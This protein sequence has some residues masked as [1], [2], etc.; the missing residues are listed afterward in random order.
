MS[1]LLPQVFIASILITALA[2]MGRSAIDTNARLYT[3]QVLQA[4]TALEAARESLVIESV[5]P[6]SPAED[7]SITLR[8]DGKR[9]IANWSSIDLIAVYTTATGQV[10]EHLSHTDGAVTPGTWAPLPTDVYQPGILNLDETLN[11]RAYLSTTPQS[12][13]NARIILTLESGATFSF[14]FA[15]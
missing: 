11:L 14:V 8:N 2:I 1:G 3:S 13:S 6:G 7:L 15:V 4:T 10:T 9:D 12:G 5:T